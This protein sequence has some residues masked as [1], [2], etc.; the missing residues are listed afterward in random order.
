MIKSFIERIKGLFGSTGSF[1]R[2]S[3]IMS[4]GAMINILIA[5]FLTPVVARIFTKEEFGVFY[6]Y[7]SIVTTSSLVIS[8]MYPHALV[9][10]KYRKDFL[11]LLKLCFITCFAGVLIFTA[12]LFIGKFKLLPL[13]GADKLIE[14][15]Y[16]LPIGLLL[17]T[18]N[19]ILINWNVR[20]KK[21][22]K[23]AE[24]I[25]ATS[26]TVKSVQIGYGSLVSSTFPGLIYS[27]LL[28]SLVGIIVLGASNMKRDI[29]LLSRIKTSRI[30][31][32]AKEFKKY[33]TYLLGANFVNRFTDDIPLFLISASFGAKAVGAFGFA[34]SMMLIPYSVLG[35]SITPV[36]FQKAKELYESDILELQNFTKKTYLIMV[37]LASLSYGFIFGFGDILFKFVFSQEWEQAGR[38]A[39]VL[40]IYYVVKIISSPF[41]KIF[42]VVRKEHLSL[43]L[44][45]IL[46]LS[47][48][49]GVYIGL[50]TDQLDMVI[51]LFALGN[52]IG[53][54]STN[55][56]VFKTLKINF[57]KQFILTTVI[58]GSIFSGYYLLRILLINFLN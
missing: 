41:S 37:I 18:V 14:F 20:R 5:F 17:T 1:R 8:G 55:F 53:Y 44:T 19:V 10:P 33:P 34:R 21:F 28:S 32:Q 29:L 50:S 40:S 39:S 27:N 22:K 57:I 49:L 54:G 25:V 38:I 16:L 47:R 6:I 15:W 52:L 42:L 51:L 4:S 56:Y 26:A 7:M 23:N 9:V 2:N 30:I 12:V 58:V 3:M 24:S 46:A 11:A 36:Y 35:N 45:T 13:I 48:I 43:Y 31:A